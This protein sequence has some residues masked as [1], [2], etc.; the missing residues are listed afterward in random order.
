MVVDG[1]SFILLSR[2]TSGCRTLQ[3]SEY[4]THDV[5]EHAISAAAGWFAG[6]GEEFHA[7]LQHRPLLIYHRLVEE[8]GPEHPRYRRIGRIPIGLASQ[9]Q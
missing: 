2:G 3:R 8:T 6:G 7:I 9:P 1:R 4:R 5:P